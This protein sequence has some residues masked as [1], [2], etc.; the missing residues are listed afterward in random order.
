MTYIYYFTP[1]L[2]KAGILDDRDLALFVYERFPEAIQLE[3]KHIDA[4]LE[5]LLD[6]SLSMVTMNPCVLNY[7][8][9]EVAAQ[10]VI[11]YTPS[12]GYMQFGDIPKLMYRLV[13]LGPGEAI[14]DVDLTTL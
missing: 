1:P 11:V 5:Y 13:A 8:G 7:I 12:R 6:N 3:I 10:I 9:D 14:L 4:W 2:N